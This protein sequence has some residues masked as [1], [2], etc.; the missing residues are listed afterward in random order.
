MRSARSDAPAAPPRFYLAID[1]AGEL[2]AVTG[3]RFVIG[4]QRAGRADLPFLADLDAEHAAL[5]WGESFH[6]GAAWTLALLG[7]ARERAPIEIDGI[8]HGAGPVELRDGARV[9]LASNLSFVFRRPEPAS[10]SAVLELE[11]GLECAGAP[12]VLLLGA[13]AA[14]RVRIGPARG[15]HVRA[16][17][18]PD[19]L[20]LELRDGALRIECASGLHEAASARER[21]APTALALALPP[22]RTVAVV[23]EK[24]APGRPPFGLSIRGS[25]LDPP[26]HDAR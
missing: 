7:G 18:A 26:R 21:A 24:R 25:E 15:R 19:E 2:Y 14:G 23:L 12:R 1:D 4:H 16:P 5:E 8:A 22:A 6:G 3:T 13:G 9:R 11:H 20:A 10:S 17:G